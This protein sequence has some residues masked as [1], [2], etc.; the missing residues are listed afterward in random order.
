MY[1]TLKVAHIF[2]KLLSDTIIEWG[3][4]SN[5]Y[6]QY[7]A[8]KIVNGKQF[9]KMGQVLWMRHFLDAQGNCVPTTTI[10]RDNKCTKL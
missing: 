4:I 9:T 8:N 1:G 6:D 3:F 5:P 2:W 7:V 10:Y